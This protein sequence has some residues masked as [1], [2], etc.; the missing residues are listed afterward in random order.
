MCEEGDRVC[1]SKEHD[2]E[3]MTKMCDDDEMMSG[4]VQG[5][6]MSN[7]QTNK[8]THTYLIKATTQRG[9]KDKALVLLLLLLLLLLFGIVAE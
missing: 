5:R 6:T 2:D 3:L 7:K 4:Y 1:L 8:Q 9:E